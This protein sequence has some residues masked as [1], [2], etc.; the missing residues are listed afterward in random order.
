MRKAPVCTGA[1]SL[2]SVGCLERRAASSAAAR[3]NN[4]HGEMMRVHPASSSRQR[5]RFWWAIAPPA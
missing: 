3:N 2:S 5:D 4:G 1:F